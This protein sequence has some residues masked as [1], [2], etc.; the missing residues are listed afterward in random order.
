M[1]HAFDT[2]FITS[3]DIIPA[4]FNDLSTFLINHWG[5]CYYEYDDDGPLCLYNAQCA[6]EMNKLITAMKSVDSFVMFVAS[7]LTDFEKMSEVGMFEYNDK[8][9]PFGLYFDVRRP[10]KYIV[11]VHSEMRTSKDIGIINPYRATLCNSV[12]QGFS[13]VTPDDPTTSIFGKEL[14][15]CLESS[16]M[17]LSV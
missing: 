17:K 8:S 14:V 3:R 5:N 9:F 6:D 10:A 16:M 7:S 11:T 2:I 13:L 12:L 15:A 1:P 4:L